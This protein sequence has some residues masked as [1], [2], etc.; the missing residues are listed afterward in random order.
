MIGA[1]K[2]DIF[3]LTLYMWVYIFYVK[4]IFAI[5]EYSRALLVLFNY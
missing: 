2:D 1:V 5:L 4:Y 3:F